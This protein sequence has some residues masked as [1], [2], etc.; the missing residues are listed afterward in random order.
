LIVAVGLMDCF[1]SDQKDTA[2][3]EMDRIRKPT[4]ESYFLND[5]YNSE[6]GYLDGTA[7]ELKIGAIHGGLTIS[8]D[9]TSQFLMY[10]WR[11]TNV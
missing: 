1:T 3:T 7:W 8:T 9:V 11:T 6:Y 2:L 5:K 10:G 4:G